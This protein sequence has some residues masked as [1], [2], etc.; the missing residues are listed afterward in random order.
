VAV[1]ACAAD[2]T[3][4]IMMSKAAVVALAVAALAAASP[5]NDADKQ[6]W[7]QLFNG[8]N[9]DGWTPKFAK[10]DLGENFNDTVRVEN[11]V[12]EIRY[13]KWQKFNGEFGH[14]FYKDP[15]SYY[16]LVAE[17][18]FVGE[19][20]PGGATWAIRNNGLM[21]HCQKPSTMGKDQD[22]P[23]SI[24]VQLLGGL[25]DGKPRST[26]NVCTPGSNIFLNGVLHTQHCTNSTSKT[27]D[28]DQW[29]RVEAEVHGDELI[30]H[31]ID[32]RTVMEYTKPQ[33]GGGS[34]SNFDPAVK[35]DGQPM[36]SGYISIQAETAP[37]DFRKI[38]LLNLEGCM[39]SK[40]KNYKKYFVKSNS[41]MCRY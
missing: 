33:I 21:I 38:E 2:Y 28:G 6:E 18:R 16:R 26:A 35:V 7:L 37:T 25:S 17:Y 32:G 5:Q 8:R 39:D 14:I 1:D 12:L 24:E 15:F 13:D 23:I 20:V 9:L 3:G 4:R 30:R 41:Q 27:Y 19:Q 34:V 11:G 36:A 31:I 22:F 40:A 29:V 10:H